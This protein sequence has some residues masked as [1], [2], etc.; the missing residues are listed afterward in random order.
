MPCALYFQVISIWS[1]RRALAKHLYLQKLRFRTSFSILLLF[2]NQ[3]QHLRSWGFGNLHSRAKLMHQKWQRN[4][5]AQIFAK[6]SASTRRR[7]FRPAHGSREKNLRAEGPQIFFETVSVEQGFMT[8]KVCFMTEKVFVL[9]QPVLH[10]GVGSSCW[11]LEG[12]GTYQLEDMG[13]S[14]LGHWVSRLRRR[15]IASSF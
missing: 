14:G 7:R 11:G 9:M 2:C 8:K 15:V 10:V 5:A 1:L 4:T 6:F 3:S 13:T 12:F